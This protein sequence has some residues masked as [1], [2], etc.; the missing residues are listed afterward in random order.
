MP[1]IE[2]PDPIAFE[3]DQGN[4]EKNW[5]KHRITIEECEEIFHDQD[6]FVQEDN[7]HSGS[8][9]RFIIIGRTKSLRKLFVVFTT[10][11]KYVRIIS[12]RN[13]HAKEVKF[14]EE[15]ARFAKI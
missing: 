12:A 3:W 13:M 9:E 2:L 5:I 6:L 8:E 7:L 10:R 11:N 4:R 1:I 15:K 14:Y